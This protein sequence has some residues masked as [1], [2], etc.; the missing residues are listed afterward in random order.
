LDS[1]T[2]EASFRH[3]LQLISEK[4][5]FKDLLGAVR[6]R[7]IIGCKDC[8]RLLEKAGTSHDTGAAA[9]MLVLG[10]APD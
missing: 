2:D 10:R 4:P 9:D 8:C 1:E 5:D 6:L 3:L 7:E